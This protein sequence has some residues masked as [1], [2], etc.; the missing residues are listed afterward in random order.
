MSMES[1][2]HDLG[3]QTAAIVLADNSSRKTRDKYLVK[4]DFPVLELG[5]TDVRT[6]SPGHFDGEPD[7]FETGAGRLLDKLANLARFLFRRKFA[8]LTPFAPGPKL[9]RVPVL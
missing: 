5:H 2:Q 1:G 4:T 6:E 7:A 3:R 8:R 9:Q